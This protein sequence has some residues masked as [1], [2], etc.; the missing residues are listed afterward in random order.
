MKKNVFIKSVLSLSILSLSL[1][2]SASALNTTSNL[3]FVNFDNSQTKQYLDNTSYNIFDKSISMYI[4][5]SYKNDYSAYYMMYSKASEGK[6]NSVELTKDNSYSMNN[7]IRLDI[8]DVKYDYVLRVALFKDQ[9]KYYENT[10]L[11]ETLA[12]SNTNQDYVVQPNRVDNNVVVNPVIAPV[13]DNTK[14]AKTYDVSIKYTDKVARPIYVYG[15]LKKDIN[16]DRSDFAIKG[17]VKDKITALKPGWYYVYAG[18]KKLG[19]L[20]ELRGTPKMY[21]NNVMM[22][23]FYWDKWK[24]SYGSFFTV[25]EDGK[26][27]QGLVDLK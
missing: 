19:W 1:F 10:Y 26:V 4:D 6:F 11:I 15:L 7:G 2:S 20:N 17:L 25:K 3:V 9:T 24:M 16:S 18:S 5:S 22:T 12:K 14:K 13:V 23:K 8:Q 21:V 27:I